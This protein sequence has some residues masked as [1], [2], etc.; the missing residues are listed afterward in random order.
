MPILPP[1]STITR[2][3]AVGSK[4]GDVIGVKCEHLVSQGGYIRGITHDYE[5]LRSLPGTYAA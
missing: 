1:Q 2:T 5:R 4:E 3:L